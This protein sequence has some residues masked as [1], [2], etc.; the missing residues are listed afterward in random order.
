MAKFAQYAIAA[1]EE[2]LEDAGWK[3]TSEEDKEAT[4]RFYSC[5]LL[6]HFAK[7]RR[8][9]VSAQESELSRM[10]MILPLRTR[11]E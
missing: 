11:K 6:I 1:T 5:E 10:F 2:A 4:V 3:P 7:L 9:F 8:E